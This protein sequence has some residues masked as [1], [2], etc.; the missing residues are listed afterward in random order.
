MDGPKEGECMAHE[1][2][3]IWVP[4]RRCDLKP[5]RVKLIRNVL[6]RIPQLPSSVRKIIELTTRMDVDSKQIAD[7]VS[8][9]PALVSKILMMVNSSYY[10]LNRK[11][12]NL[13]LAIVLLGFN[14]IRNLAIKSGFFQTLGEMSGGMYDPRDLWMHSYLVS[15][16]SEAFADE[17]EPQRAGVLV[18][19]GMLHDIGKFALHL[20]GMAMDAKGVRPPDVELPPDAY[21][22]EREERR[23]GVNHAIIGGMLAEKWNLSERI[24]SVLEYHHH[25]SFFGVNEIPSEFEED[26][27]I[28]CLS[29]LVVN[30]IENRERRL[31]EPHPVFFSLLGLEP[32]LDN[33]ITPELRDQL[34]RAKAFVNELAD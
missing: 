20:I 9:D 18:T 29:D 24:T 8:S 2:E 12:D 14:E 33:L 17:D 30:R 7:V 10:G 4:R 5:E 15:I 1:Q 19:L 3:R 11:I 27:T 31:N 25:P 26:V 16:F 28:I 22:M 32:P 21:L 6:N 34:D 13:R 23:F